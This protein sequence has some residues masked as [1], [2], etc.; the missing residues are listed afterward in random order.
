MTDSSAHVTK[1]IEHKVHESGID[2]KEV[3]EE[4][5]EEVAKLESFG[6]GIFEERHILNCSFGIDNFGLA[7]A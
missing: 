2:P 7:F 1:N 3:K 4:T 5:G 6:R